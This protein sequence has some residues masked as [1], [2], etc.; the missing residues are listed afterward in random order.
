M[1]PNRQAMTDECKPTT[2]NQQ[3]TNHKTVRLA[4]FAS[5][6]GSNAQQIINYFRESINVKIVLIVCNNPKAGVLAIASKENIP[7]FLLEKNKFLETGYVAELKSYQ[8][9]FIIL[10]GFLWKVP[11]V[12]I[13]AF[14]NKIINIHP[15]L[16]P[17]Y[18][19][20]GMY[21]SAV[22]SAVIAAKEKESGITIHF[23]DEKYDHGEII[24]QVKC[25]ISENETSES[26]AE[27]IHKLEHE[28]YP[29]IIASIVERS[30]VT[31]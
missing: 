25:E 30:A 29:K 4:I 8:T 2:D 17:A 22:H 23:V 11:Q 31:I 27:K 6:A 19:G 13:N 1:N 21:G 16:L 14:Q 28:N 7:V 24:F 26:L 20:K 15:A 18:G 10:A 9:D 5:G 3:P 12:L